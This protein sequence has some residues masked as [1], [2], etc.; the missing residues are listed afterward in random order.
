MLEYSSR[1]EPNMT[2][3][4]DRYT[5]EGLK[6]KRERERKYSKEVKRLKKTKLAFDVDKDSKYPNIWKSIPN[7]AKFMRECLDRY[8]EEHKNE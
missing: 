1:E 5:E 6:K 8:E 4:K 3:W 2:D 7:K